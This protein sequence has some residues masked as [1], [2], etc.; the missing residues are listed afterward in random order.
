MSFWFPGPREGGER[1]FHGAGD[2]PYNAQRRADT[3]QARVVRVA[4]VKV[5]DFSVCE[6]LGSSI[7]DILDRC[8]ST[9][10]KELRLEHVRRE[11]VRDGEH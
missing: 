3:V 6:T 5:M 7:S 8:N 11:K 9:A 2:V 4:H 10:K 1:S